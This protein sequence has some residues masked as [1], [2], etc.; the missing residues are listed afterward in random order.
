MESST[1]QPPAPAPPPRRGDVSVGGVINETFSIYGENLGPLIAS[2]LIVFVV[3]GIASGLLTNAGGIILG[4]LALIV[5]LVGQAIYVGFV[6]NLVE[7]VRDGRRDH[8]MG[9]L[10]SAASPAI[11]A[12]IGFGILFAI[13]VGIGFVLLI[14]PGLFLITMWCV[15]APAIVVEKIGVFD[16]FGRSW[17]LVKQNGWSVFGALLVTLIIVFAIQFVLALIGT[18]IGLGG[19]L[20][21]NI[22]SGAITAPIFA[23]AVTVIYFELAGGFAAPAAEP[24]APDPVRE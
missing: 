1:P 11:P 19:V 12:L 14:I 10:F 18:A 13:G 7:D 4:V 22:I 21:A 23:I 20:V 8:S 6:V 15:G 24:A 3:V 2:A 5:S 17:G 16:A 9:D